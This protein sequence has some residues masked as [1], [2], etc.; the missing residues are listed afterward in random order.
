MPAFDPYY[1]QMPP[2]NNDFM[3]PGFQ[4]STVAVNP[5]RPSFDFPSPLQQPSIVTNQYRPSF[6]FLSQSSEWQPVPLG[7]HGLL[8]GTVNTTS[9]G[10]TTSHMPAIPY[11][12]QI[13]PPPPT[14]PNHPSGATIGHT[15][16]STSRAGSHPGIFAPLTPNSRLVASQ[17]PGLGWPSSQALLNQRRYNGLHPL[18]IPDRVFLTDPSPATNW[19]HMPPSLFNGEGQ[20]HQQLRLMS[21]SPPASRGCPPHPG[22]YMTLGAA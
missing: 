9:V 6:D 1:T 15:A 8:A 16:S 21:Y 11:A 12:Q 14:T 20:T 10:P 19:L 5:Y 2:V 4:Q 18:H 7:M 22:G 3:N 13:A 17:S